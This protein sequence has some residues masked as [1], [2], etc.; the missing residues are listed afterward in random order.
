MRKHSD[1]FP[2][3]LLF[4][5]YVI[6]EALKT[7]YGDL[8]KAWLQRQL[9]L[10][11]YSDVATSLVSG[12]AEI[13]PALTVAGLIVV[14]LYWYIR[15]DFQRIHTTRATQIREQLEQ[16]YIHAGTILGRKLPKDISKD[17]FEKYVAEADSWANT[18]GNWIGTNLGTAARARFF[19]RTGMMAV[20]V[21]GAVNKEHDNLIQSITRLR[22]NLATLI[23]NKVWEQAPP[24]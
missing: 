24:R 17:D 1:A 14:A 6:A 8:V 13:V 5:A 21:L 22:K 19:D 12:L 18:A 11:G 10:R 23:D 15:R 9:A 7:A 2:F 16:F 4:G 3:V 20:T